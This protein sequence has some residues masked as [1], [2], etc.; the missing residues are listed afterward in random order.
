MNLKPFDL[1]KA[2][3]GEPVVTR[4]G[5]EVTQLKKFDVD[6]EPLVGVHDGT[7][8]TWEIDG[9]YINHTQES[10]L[11]LFMAPVEKV[12]WVNVYE[13]DGGRITLGN[14]YNTEDA[15]TGGKDCFAS[16]Y[17]GAFP[18]TIKL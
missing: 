9:S 12:V 10:L 13:K 6:G 7:I 3:A 14:F 18:L 5:Q 8:E 15:A 4:D 17:L 16:K 11:D 1:E 2:L